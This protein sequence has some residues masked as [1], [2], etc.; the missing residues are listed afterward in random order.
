[1]QTKKK[2]ILSF[3]LSE[4]GENVFFAKRPKE[5]LSE[6]IISSSSNYEWI[7]SQNNGAFRIFQMAC[8]AQAKNE[9]DPLRFAIS[10]ESFLAGL[11]SGMPNKFVKDF[12]SWNKAVPN[13]S[14][15]INEWHHIYSDSSIDFLS[16]LRIKNPEKFTELSKYKPLLNCVEET[17]PNWGFV[18]KEGSEKKIREMLANFSLEPCSS[19]SNQ[20]KE[21]PLHKFAE[22]E[23]FASP[24]PVA[25]GGDAMFN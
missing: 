1:M 14:A 12:L 11:H 22:T 18:I 24:S 2:N 25:E 15:A 13:V 23:N 8:L 9:E 10:K 19:A 6:P 20:L 7:L 4:F 3:S 17:I 5:N 16:I 21:E